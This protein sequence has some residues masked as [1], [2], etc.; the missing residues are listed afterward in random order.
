MFRIKYYLYCYSS[1]DNG[2]IENKIHEKIVLDF[3]L[4]NIDIIKKYNLQIIFESNF[5][6]KN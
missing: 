2:S 4:K 6:P 5:A 3:F 1:S